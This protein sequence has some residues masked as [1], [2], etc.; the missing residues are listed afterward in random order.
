MVNAIFFL[1]LPKYDSIHIKN[2]SYDTVNA[3]QKRFGEAK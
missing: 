1:I 2:F 3:I